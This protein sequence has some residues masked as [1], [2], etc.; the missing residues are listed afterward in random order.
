VVQYYH[1]D[2]G[3]ILTDDVE[4]R[5]FCIS[6]SNFFLGNAINTLRNGF[7]SLGEKTVEGGYPAPYEIE[8]YELRIWWPYTGSTTYWLGFS[9]PQTVSD[10]IYIGLR[11][12]VG[13][14]VIG[15][16]G[17][18]DSETGN[19]YLLELYPDASNQDFSLIKDI[20]G[21]VSSM[22]SEAV[23]L[24][25][26]KLYDVGLYVDFENGRICA[27]RDGEEKLRVTNTEIS[28]VDRIIFWMKSGSQ[29]EGV[30]FAVPLV[31]TYR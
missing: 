4:K 29:Y 14:N 2:V 23:D 8:K 22:A 11:M 7:K 6:K 16:F 1:S 15:R 28:K 30:R 13:L 20:D 3:G 19:K 18:M 25:R 24:E 9:L 27:F 5:V 10:Q 26:N 31:I 12:A 21:S 17:V